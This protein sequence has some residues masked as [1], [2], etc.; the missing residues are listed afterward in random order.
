MIEHS[1]YKSRKVFYSVK[2]FKSLPFEETFSSKMLGDPC[3]TSGGDIDVV[4]GR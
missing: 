1:I 2:T 3:P 4:N